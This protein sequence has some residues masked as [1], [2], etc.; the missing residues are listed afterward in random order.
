MIVEYLTQQNM[1]AF[2]GGVDE[3]PYFAPDS[4]A[5]EVPLLPAAAGGPPFD[6]KNYLRNG[7]S[8]RYFDANDNIRVLSIGIVFPYAYSISTNYI[9]AFPVWKDNQLIPVAGNVWEFTGDPAGTSLVRLPY[10]GAEFPVDVTIAHK[11]PGHGV[12]F[13]MIAATAAPNIPMVSMINAPLKLDKAVTHSD[14]HAWF[15]WKIVHTL[16]MI[17]G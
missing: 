13:T 6:P 4:T 8:Y 7:L 2:P 10:D 5:L 16:P 12:A 15:F 1:T 17:A 3:R 9:A 11:S 14:L